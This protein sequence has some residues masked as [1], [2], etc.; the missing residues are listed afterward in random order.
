MGLGH[1]LHLRFRYIFYVIIFYPIMLLCVGADRCRLRLTCL[2][3]VTIAPLSFV[4]D[5]RGREIERDSSWLMNSPLEEK[6]NI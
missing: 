5:F 6:L 2:V 3:S 4:V 1:A